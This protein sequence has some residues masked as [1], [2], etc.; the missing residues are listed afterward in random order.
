MI[1]NQLTTSNSKIT[2]CIFGMYTKG[3]V[4]FQRLT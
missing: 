2:V 4:G 3:N 1:N